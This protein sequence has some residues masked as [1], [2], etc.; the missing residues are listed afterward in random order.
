MEFIRFS[1]QMYHLQSVFDNAEKYRVERYDELLNQ[2]REN[3]FPQF[4]GRYGMDSFKEFNV[5]ELLYTPML[6]QALFLIA[7][8]AFELQLS[9]IAECMEK[10]H[11]RRKKIITIS[12]RGKSYVELYRKYLHEVQQVR[13]A[14]QTPL[15]SRLDDFRLIRNSIVHNG[16]KIEPKD[17]KRV[18]SLLDAYRATYNTPPLPLVIRDVNFLKDFLL[19]TTTYL[20]QIVFEIA[21]VPPLPISRGVV[22]P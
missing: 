2:I 5:I 6:L 9:S 16:G 21:P 11:S 20:K 8:S 13:S 3:S 1:T 18:S 10:Q 15:W 7:Y 19:A 4:I 14:T 12:K 17:L 22:R